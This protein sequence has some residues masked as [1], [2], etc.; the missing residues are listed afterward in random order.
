MTSISKE[1]I[2]PKTDAL[3]ERAQA[4]LNSVLYITRYESTKVISELI[5]DLITQYQT[6]LSAVEIIEDGEPQVGD[7]VEFQDGGRQVVMVT[8]DDE[9]AAVYEQ[10]L[11]ITFFREHNDERFR[12]IQRSGK[13]CI[14]RSAITTSKEGSHDNN[15]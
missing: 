8:S 2:E 6:L 1:P 10:G 13:S 4:M 12:I 14:L 15:I 3:I 9:D 7:V 5:R 11:N